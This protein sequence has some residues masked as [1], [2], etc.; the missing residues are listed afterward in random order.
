LRCAGRDEGALKVGIKRVEG[1][2]FSTWAN[3]ELRPG[4]VLEI[5]EIWRLA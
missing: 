1:G 5:E 3:Q 4:D 2:A